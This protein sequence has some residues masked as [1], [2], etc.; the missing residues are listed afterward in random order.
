MLQ[1]NFM[2]QVL[3]FLKIKIPSF[4]VDR[5]SNQNKSLLG[6]KSEIMD[7][8]FYF[9]IDDCIYVIGLQGKGASYMQSDYFCCC[10][11]LMWIKMSL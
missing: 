9:L 8:Q 11:F 5:L 1:M 6:Y 3:P 10:F 4:I 7:Q 2:L